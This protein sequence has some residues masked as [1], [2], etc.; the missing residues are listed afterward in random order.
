VLLVTRSLLALLAFGACSKHAPVEVRDA[1]STPGSSKATPST[2]RPLQSGAE[3]VDAP[4]AAAQPESTQAASSSS[5]PNDPPLAEPLAPECAD[6]RVVLAVRKQYDRSG[7]VRVQQ[8]LLANPEFRLVAEHAR[9]PGE[10]DVYETIYGLKG[11]APRPPGVPMFSEAVIAR[12]S[13]AA[14]CN[15][16]GAAFQAASRQDRPQPSCGVPGAT[17]GGFARVRELGA[18]SMVLPGPA[19]SNVARCARIDACLARE[20][21]PKRTPADCRGVAAGALARCAPL[22][23][24]PGV[25]RCIEQE[26]D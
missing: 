16:L 7:R 2:A 17:T 20:H 18:G 9:A 3:A 1:A 22:P 11:F 25:A 13:D 15:R 4:P 10:V 6:P 5:V 19:A 14:T 23:D 12:C 8:F 21:A 24:C 26:L